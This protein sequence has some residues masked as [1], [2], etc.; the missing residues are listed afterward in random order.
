[1]SKR[2]RDFRGAAAG[3]ERPADVQPRRGEL[4][5]RAR[6]DSSEKSGVLDK[7]D[8]V[9]LQYCNNDMRENL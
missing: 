3:A 2:R 7:V 4:W 6:T 8:T 5:H 1:V 9:I